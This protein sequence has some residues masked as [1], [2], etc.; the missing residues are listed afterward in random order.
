MNI[1]QNLDKITTFTITSSQKQLCS[2]PGCWVGGWG[3]AG[4]VNEFN[5]YLY[6]IRAAFFP[7]LQQ[8][9]FLCSWQAEEEE[10]ESPPPAES[11]GWTQQTL[12][13]NLL[14]FTPSWGFWFEVKGNSCW[15]FLWSM[16]VLH[17]HI[18][19]ILHILIN[20]QKE[21][22]THILYLCWIAIKPVF[23]H[24]DTCRCYTFAAQTD[25]R[26]DQDW[27]SVSNPRWSGE[28]NHLP[29]LKCVLSGKFKQ[30]SK[31]PCLWSR[32]GCWKPPGGASKRKDE[33]L[34]SWHCSHSQHQG[35]VISHTSTNQRVTDPPKLLLWIRFKMLCA[36]T[37]F[38]PPSSR[39][40]PRCVSAGTAS[41]EGG[42][43]MS[44]PLAPGNELCQGGSA[45]N[46]IFQWFTWLPLLKAHE[47][48]LETREKLLWEMLYSKRREIQQLSQNET[49]KELFHSLLLSDPCFSP[50]DLCTYC[51]Y[52][53]YQVYSLMPRPKLSHCKLP[54]REAI[55]TP[56]ALELL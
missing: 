55:S 12:G 40:G 19:F 38:Q 24:L 51:R 9:S 14:S 15:G 27:F 26:K 36:R 23:W 29:L 31:Q 30:K 6:L 8:W 49:P 33:M 53:Q 47:L 7:Q 16:N 35:N 17:I 25:H 4:R 2:F 45:A 22:Y 11:C 54:S 20:T 13:I 52:W 1:G 39:A 43:G 48:V 42:S 3:G 34:Q 44:E 50:L 10:A 21:H 41:E 32:W 46:I 56:I 37:S 28:L 5:N 18:I